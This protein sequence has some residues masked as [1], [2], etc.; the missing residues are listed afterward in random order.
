M[1]EPWLVRKYHRKRQKLARNKARIVA[2]LQK[3]L[4]AQGQPPF[5][6]RLIRWLLGLLAP[7][8]RYL[9]MAGYADCSRPVATLAPATGYV[10]E[11]P[12]QIGA[13]PAR[14]PGQ[15]PPIEARLFT[16]AEI[17]PTSSAIVTGGRI[18]VPP[19]YIGR[20]D[21][22]ITDGEFFLSQDDGT[23]IAFCPNPARVERGVALFGAGVT[24]WY[25][26]LIEI[27]PAAFLAES[28]PA[29][30]GDFP[31]LVPAACQQYETF[32][33]SLA[34]FTQGRPVT[35]LA[36][37]VPAKVGRLV[38]IDSPVS[39]PMNLIA[40][41]W[42]APSDYS[43]NGEVLARF[44]AAI[45]D[46]LS[47]DEA[48]PTRR[49]FLARGNDRRNYNQAE[50]LEIAA[51]HGFE[52]VYPEKLSFREQVATFA[53]AEIVAGPSGAA[54]ANMLFCQNRTRGLT[55]LLPHYEGFC[56][57]SNLANVVGMDLRYLFVTPQ[58][59]INSS[60]DAYSAAYT[61]E[62]ERFEVALKAL[63]SRQP[64][65]APAQ[66]DRRAHFGSR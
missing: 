48:P 26:W 62:A 42:P 65:P 17:Y 6:S 34:L 58:T 38:H 49:I 16:A 32:R 57:Y 3:K 13:P 56:A 39:G 20:P 61:L 21:L 47:I 45:L 37:A 36:P 22:L 55:W 63:L 43:Q 52:P 25:H 2:K 50:L 14:Q 29:E 44:R 8:N 4:T 5:R 9:P 59:P 33:A 46:R 35:T 54:F 24:N 1:S 28:L 19:L 18:A 7:A 10:T 53:G 51:G 30:F 11:A 41:R 64:E 12:R 60:Y 66:A 40:G 23:G 27:L 31:L 15:L